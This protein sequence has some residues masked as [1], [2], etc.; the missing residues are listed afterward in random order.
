MCEALHCT[1]AGE[2]RELL[3]FSSSGLAW[4]SLHRAAAYQPSSPSTADVPGLHASCHIAHLQQEAHWAL[5]EVLEPWYP[6]SQGRLAR[7]L[8]MAS[9]LKNIPCSL[10]VDLF[11]RPIIGDVDITELLEDMLLLR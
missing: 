9:T 7:I 3:A 6:V 2:G 8:L 11:F 5:C 1:P 10:L 4:A